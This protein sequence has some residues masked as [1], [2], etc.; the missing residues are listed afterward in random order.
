MTSTITGREA[1]TLRKIV[2]SGEIGILVSEL[3]LR[4]VTRLARRG[5][6]RTVDPHRQSIESGAK[7]RAA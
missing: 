7:V 5:L 1:A 3:D 6:I 4:H 2:K